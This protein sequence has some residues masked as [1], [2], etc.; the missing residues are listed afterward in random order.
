MPS[1]AGKKIQK[2]L[3]CDFVKDIDARATICRKLASLFTNEAICIDCDKNFKAE[4]EVFVN[5]ISIS[6]LITQSITPE[7]WFD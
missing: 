5:Y 1:F 7:L 4:N 3:F 2:K 6:D